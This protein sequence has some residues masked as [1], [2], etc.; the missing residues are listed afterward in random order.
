MYKKPI[1]ACPLNL[2]P[3]TSTSMTLVIGDCIAMAL[4]ELKGFKSNHFKNLHPGGNLGKDLKYVSELMHTKNEIPI[5]LPKNLCA[6]SHQNII[7]NS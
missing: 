7:L 2:A 5:N 4:L 6:H 1:E 3:T